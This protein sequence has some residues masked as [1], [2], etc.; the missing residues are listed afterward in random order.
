LSIRTGISCTEIVI[1]AIN[2]G[3]YAVSSAGI[4]R[5]ISA[6]IIIIANNF[7]RSTNSSNTN[8]SGTRIT[9]IT[10]NRGSIA[11]SSV[12]IT[13]VD[14]TIIVIITNNDRVGA[15]KSYVTTYI[16]ARNFKTSNSPVVTSSGLIASILS[17]GILIITAN[18]NIDTISRCNITTISGTSILIVAVYSHVLTKSRIF[19]ATISGTRIFVITVYRSINTTCIIITGIIGT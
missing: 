14:G 16:F 13:L 8:V 1:I 6:R 5:I 15:A 11:G 17:T 9:V 10:D 7:F 2:R 4:A 19:T 3:I 12:N 18:G